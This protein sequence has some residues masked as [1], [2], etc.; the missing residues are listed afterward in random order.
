M[1][2]PKCCSEYVEGIQ[3]C[4][5]CNVSL[6]E[7]EP[8]IPP[9][10]WKPKLKIATMLA[11]LGGIYMFCTKTF[12]TFF[13]GTI[14]NAYLIRTNVILWFLGSVAWIFFLIAFYK[15]YLKKGQSRLSRALVLAIFGA[16]L[17][18]LLRIYSLFLVFE[19][20]IIVSAK[21][22]QMMT[23][24]FPLISLLFYFMFL[25]AFYKEQ[26]SPKQK[27]LK[28]AILYAAIGST[29]LIASHLFVWID[30][31]ILNFGFNLDYWSM[32]QGNV[33][34]VAI[35]LPIGAFS[36]IAEIYFMVTFYK[37]IS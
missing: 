22:M 35:L 7:E 5:D 29:V 17:M 31:Y 37:S 32:Y 28:I 14:L 12:F 13:P 6:Q 20:K 15:E 4:P 9:K 16:S 33:V 10:Q 30:A 21:L 23:T 26:T 11:L 19:I 25:L 34:L 2:C 36:L 27:K 3:Q 8:Q 18:L 1:F 24:N